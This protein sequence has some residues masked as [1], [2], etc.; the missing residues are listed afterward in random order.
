[1]L[2]SWIRRSRL[3]GEDWEEGEVPLGEE[4]EDYR[5]D[6]LAGDAVRRSVRLGSPE[7]R[8]GAS[9]IAADFGADPGS[10]RLRIAQ[11]STIFGAGAALERII[12]V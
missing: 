10:F 11:V 6:I 7:Y 5:L 12:D 1:M 2:F 4:R 3:A 9:E 8:Y